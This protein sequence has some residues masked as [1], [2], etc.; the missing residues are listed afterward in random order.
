MWRRKIPNKTIKAVV[1]FI[2]AYMVFFIIWIQ[3][4]NYYAVALIYAASPLACVTKDASF[5]ILMQSGDTVK[6]KLILKK[7]KEE[8][9]LSIST[10]RY[11]YNTPLTLAIATVFIPWIYRRRQA[12]LYTLIILLSVHL[13]Y[14]YSLE[15]LALTRVIYDKSLHDVGVIEMNVHVV[16]YH[17]TDYLL[18]RF[19]PF[20]MGF[21]LYFK[22][23]RKTHTTIGHL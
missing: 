1:I 9:N 19:E 4:K 5:E 11:T 23:V 8:C 2:V 14:L 6:I 21:V 10:S 12:L 7:F 3:V 17:F 18:L 13:L 16:L 20:L 22:F 15:T